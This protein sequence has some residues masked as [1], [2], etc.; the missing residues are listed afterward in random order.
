MQNPGVGV[1]DLQG[2]E[3]S[4]PSWEALSLLCP[5]QATGA[6]TTPIKFNGSQD[7]ATEGFV[8]LG[9]FFVFVF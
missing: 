8:G 5:V 3:T 2:A 6:P 7:A 1:Q 4:K 9:L